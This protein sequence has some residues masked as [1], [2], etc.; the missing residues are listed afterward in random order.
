MLLA[1]LAA[2]LHAVFAAM[3]KGRIDPWVMRGAMDASYG[4]MALPFAARGA[5]ARGAFMANFGRGMGD[6]HCL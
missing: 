4:L 6:P 2:V 1:L 5:L 3:Q